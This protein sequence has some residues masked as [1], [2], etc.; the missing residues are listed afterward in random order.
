MICM[1]LLAIVKWPVFCHFGVAPFSTITVKTTDGGEESG[2][3]VRDVVCLNDA[4]TL[5][6]YKCGLWK[7]LKLIF[8]NCQLKW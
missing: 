7:S 5:V 3:V 8:S 4:F 1:D 6:D 2:P